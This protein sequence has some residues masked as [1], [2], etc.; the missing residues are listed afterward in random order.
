MCLFSNHI[1][2]LAL[3]FLF[4]ALQHQVLRKLKPWAECSQWI[5]WGETECSDIK[6]LMVFTPCNF[7][8]H[9]TQSPKDSLGEGSVEW[10]VTLQLLELHQLRISHNA[11]AE[12]ALLYGRFSF[13]QCCCLFL[14][15]KQWMR[16]Q[17]F[18]LREIMCKNRWIFSIISSTCLH[19]E[20]LFG[21]EGAKVP[22]PGIK[23]LSETGAV[24]GACPWPVLQAH[25]G[26]GVHS[27]RAGLAKTLKVYLQKQSNSAKHGEGR[28]KQRI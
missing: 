28:I 26:A 15:R 18:V 27:N 4:F 8:L 3:V 16:C 1:F 2:V 23:N 6:G 9:S 19:S 21:A 5:L 17:I 24:C 7:H 20:E 22:G 14:P 10:G 13:S 11:P 12:T 25:R